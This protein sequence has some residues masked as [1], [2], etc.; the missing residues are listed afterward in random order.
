MTA[1]PPPVPPEQQ[2]DKA[3]KSGKED[4]KRAEKANSPE[5]DSNA[6]QSDGIKQNTR[7]KGYQQDR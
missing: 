2:S 7:N 6:N 1:Y 3:P 5:V 4:A